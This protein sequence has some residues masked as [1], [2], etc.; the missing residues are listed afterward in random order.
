MKYI[1]IAKDLDGKE[2]ARGLTQHGLARTL[3]I[4]IELIQARLKQK[5]FKYSEFKKEKNKINIEKI[6]FS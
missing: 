2:I 4:S 3:N 6:K 5:V 1:Y